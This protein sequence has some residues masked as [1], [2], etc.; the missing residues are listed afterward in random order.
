MTGLQDLRYRTM[1]ERGFRMATS[2]ASADGVLPSGVRRLRA[3][4]PIQIGDRRLLG[5]LGTGGMGVVY[6]GQD[7]LVGLVA[8]KAAHDDSTGD[9]EPRWRLAA[10]AACIRRVPDACTARLLADGTDRTLPYIVTEYVKGRSLA[11]V[12]RKDGPLPP[13]RCWRTCRMG[14]HACHPMV[15]RPRWL[16]RGG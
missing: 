10:E 7:A 6:L 12:V 5:R 8:A 4:D 13:E 1:V 14:R 11:D 2:S 15:T 3:D 9:Y 16:R